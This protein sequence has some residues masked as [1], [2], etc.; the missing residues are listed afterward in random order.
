MEAL[1]RLKLKTRRMGGSKR[2]AFSDDVTNEDVHVKNVKENL[3]GVKRP[4]LEFKPPKRVVGIC[5]YLV[6]CALE[7][8]ASQFDVLK[9]V[10]PCADVEYGIG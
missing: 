5:K 10:F 7:P 4:N 3:S 2:T 9:E 1:L 6:N 8:S